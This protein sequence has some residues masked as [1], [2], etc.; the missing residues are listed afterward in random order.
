MV[1][2]G[3]GRRHRA[4]QLLAQLFL[5]DVL[6]HRRLREGAIAESCD[7]Y[8]RLE[9]TVQLMGIAEPCL[10]PWPR[11]AIS[12]YLAAGR[13]GDAERVLA[14]LDQTA[15]RLPCRYPKI[16]AAAGRAQLADLR[17]DQAAAQ[18]HYQA[19]VALHGQVDLPI[20]HAETLLAYGAFLRRSGRPADARAVLARATALADAAGAGWLSGLAR[21]ELKVAGGRARRHPAPGTLTPQEER[22][23]VLAATGATN[24]G[25]ARQLYLSVST[26]ETHLERIYAKLGIRTRYQLI[27][28]AANA[29]WGPKK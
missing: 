22:V 19:A 21:Q 16:A 3:A 26:V 12:A 13:T 14:W 25:I 7:Y 10:P 28:M 27:A 5:W 20:E 6:G 1:P 11:H 15:Q 29:N 23:A 9:A 24:A 2:A 17:G 8:A 18:A 4:R